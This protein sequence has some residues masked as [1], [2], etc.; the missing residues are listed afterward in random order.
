LLGKR[1]A[2]NI[3]YKHVVNNIV[4]FTKR[5]AF[6]DFH[7]ILTMIAPPRP[8]RRKKY[9]NKC[10]AAT[11]AQSENNHYPLNVTRQL[12][13]SPLRAP[14]R[15]APPSVRCKTPQNPPFSAGLQNVPSN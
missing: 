8:P 15:T 3:L 12:P 11:I 5:Q 1:I 2:I 13:A 4:F 9:L 6:P 7:G 14:D 10:R